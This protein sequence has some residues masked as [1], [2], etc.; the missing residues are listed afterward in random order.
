[1]H[2]QG[3]WEVVKGRDNLHSYEKKNPPIRVELMMVS[4]IE[5]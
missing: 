2:T 5:A 1:M 4:L 3:K